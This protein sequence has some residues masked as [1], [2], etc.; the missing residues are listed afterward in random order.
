MLENT[1]NIVRGPL[2]NA[3][4]GLNAIQPRGMLLNYAQIL[5]RNKLLQNKQKSEL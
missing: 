5:K 3:Y 1:F 2:E 4:L